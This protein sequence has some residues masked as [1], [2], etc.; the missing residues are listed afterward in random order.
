MKIKESENLLKENLDELSRIFEQY[1]SFFETDKEF[2][3]QLKSKYNIQTKFIID[4]E[5]NAK[6]ISSL[7]SDMR[8]LSGEDFFLKLK[9]FIFGEFS[10]YIALLKMLFYQVVF[11]TNKQNVMELVSSSDEPAF[12]FMGGNYLL[13]TMNFKK[14]KNIINQ[15]HFKD[16]KL[17]DE[18]V[19]D[20]NTELWLVTDMEHDIFPS[21]INKVGEY[22][23]AATECVRENISGEDFQVLQHE[24]SE[25]IINAVTHGNKNDLGKIIRLWYSFKDDSYKFIIEDQGAGF[26]DLEKWND[27]NRKRNHAIQS[28]DMHL[29]KEY[30]FYRSETDDTGKGGSTLF[31]ALEYWDSGVIFSNKRNKI[32][33]VK[34]FY[35]N[36]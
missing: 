26:Q 13:L 5:K 9:N 16:I 6:A 17:R 15:F 32:V 29:M 14:I 36:D 18:L 20:N 30:A 7:I 21:D 35:S 1:N 19:I 31:G 11:Y 27:F 22:T 23:D 34:Y 25:L 24:V 28:K 33:T 8:K 3:E 2:I 10:V 12:N 4:I